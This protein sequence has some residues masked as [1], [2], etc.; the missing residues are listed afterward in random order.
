MSRDDIL[1]CRRLGQEGLSLGVVTVLL[2]LGLQELDELVKAR[3]KGGTWGVSVSAVVL[4][5]ASLWGSGNY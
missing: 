4:C 3:G 1:S 2:V 5:R